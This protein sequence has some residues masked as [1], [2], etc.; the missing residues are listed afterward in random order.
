MR[1]TSNYKDY[2]CSS[3]KGQTRVSTLPTIIDSPSRLSGIDVLSVL[4]QV[5]RAFLI[6]YKFLASFD[7]TEQLLVSLTRQII[8]CRCN[9]MRGLCRFSLFKVIG[10]L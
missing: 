6:D 10:K 3:E 2:F 4:H 9:D 8:A 5:Y 1:P 7:G